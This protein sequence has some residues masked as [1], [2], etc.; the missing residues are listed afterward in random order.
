MEVTLPKLKSTAFLKRNFNKWPDAEEYQ[1]WGI[2]SPRVCID[3]D[4]LR[5]GFRYTNSILSTVVSLDMRIWVVP[6]KNNVF[7]FEILNR[8]VGAM[9]I[10]AQSLQEQIASLAR[11]RKLDVTW[12]RHDGHPVALLRV[13]NSAESP[14]AWVNR[15]DMQP[16][17]LTIGVKP[18]EMSNARKGKFLPSPM[19]N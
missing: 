2:S 15:I 10:S 6:H 16:G 9:P 5:L 17:K 8:N 4:R 11:G 13:G 19:G 18:L 12:Y 7:A 1:K 14:Q 3:K